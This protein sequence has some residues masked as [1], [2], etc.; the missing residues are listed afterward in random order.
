MNKIEPELLQ[1][2]L[3]KKKKKKKERERTTKK[4]GHMFSGDKKKKKKTVSMALIANASLTKILLKDPS[5]GHL[6]P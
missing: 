3:R 6:S 2:R 1:N 4:K 5:K